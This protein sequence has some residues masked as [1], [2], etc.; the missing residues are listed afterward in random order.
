M[1]KSPP[2]KQAVRVTIFSRTYTLRT[3]GDPAALEALAASVDELLLSIADKSPEADT[4]RIAVLACLRLA[5][6]VRDLEGEL[7][8]IHE[9]RRQLQ[10]KTERVNGMLDRLI[11]VASDAR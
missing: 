10:D 7:K 1:E 4:T 8:E 6:K 3:S 5:D 2:E 9:L 11:S